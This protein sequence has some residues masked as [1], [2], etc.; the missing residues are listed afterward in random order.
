MKFCNKIIKW[1]EQNKRD[2]P[3]RKTKDPYIIW[4]SEII[5][6]QTR[7]EQGKPYFIKFRNQY[8]T[9]SSM[10]AANEMDILKLWQGL[11]Y[12]SRARNLLFT[13]KYI[14]NELNGVF[15][16][17]YDSLLKLKGVGKYTA[18]AIASFCYDEIVPVVD[19][20]VYRVLSRFFG[21]EHPIDT[22]IGQKYFFEL[23]NEII[24]TKD[25]ATYNQGIMEF[26]ALQCIPKKPD[27]QI[28]PINN[29]CFAYNN[30]RQTFLPVK[31]GKVKVKKLYLTYFVFCDLN[32]VVIQQR[33]AN[34]IWANLHEFPVIESSVEINL[35]QQIAENKWLYESINGSDVQFIKSF[36]HLLSHRKII[37][38]FYKVDTL[39]DLN[40]FPKKPFRISL[41]DFDD[42]PV[43]KLIDNFWHHF[44]DGGSVGQL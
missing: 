16:A 18:A 37:A 40:S 44:R 34:S 11:G 4:L 8:P 19:G 43:S 20:N 5:L 25:P 23:A 29:Q 17:D 26:G 27:C 36:V 10:A 38:N 2:L 39:P 30:D 21:V 9:V 15:P 32:Q 22:G 31:K 7:V 1:Y 28:C 12:Y 13:S 14:S 3:W 6:Q 41:I 35:N 33:D 42:F 24:S